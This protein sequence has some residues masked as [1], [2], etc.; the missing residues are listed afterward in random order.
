MG[1]EFFKFE[2]KVIT[3]VGPRE[4]GCGRGLDSEVEFDGEFEVDEL[5]GVLVAE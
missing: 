2:V 1:A 4:E 5:L 3:G